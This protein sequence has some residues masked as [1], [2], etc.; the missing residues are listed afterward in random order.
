MELVERYQIILE[1]DPRSQVFAP[2]AEAYRKMGLLE[3]AFRIC[4]R[5]VQFHPNFAGGRLAL[6]KVLT[7]RKNPEGAVKELEKAIELSP[8]NIMAHQ[9]IAELHLNMKNAKEALRAYKM[10]LFLAPNNERAQRAVRKLEALTADEFDD[11]IFAM[12]PLKQAVTTGPNEIAPGRPAQNLTPLQVPHPKSERFADLDRFLSLADAYIV[13][14]DFDR[15]EATLS[16]AERYY[17]TAPELIKRMNLLR[18]RS[19]SDEPESAEEEAPRPRKLDILDDKIGLLNDL[20]H[21]FQSRVQ[22]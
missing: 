8:E 21:R 22:S 19:Q 6:A 9:L 10:V 13:R 7:D 16:E 11:D 20:L 4:V 18:N 12:K 14:N 15:A 1:K 5:G 3:E 17:S 2:L